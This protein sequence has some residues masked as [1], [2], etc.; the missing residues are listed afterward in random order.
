MPTA[1]GRSAAVGDLELAALLLR[2]GADVNATDV[3]GTAL[4]EAAGAGRLDMVKFLLNANALSAVCGATGYDGAIRR[5]EFRGNPAV[6]DLI[7]EH[8]A[9]VEAGTVFNPELL[10]AQQECRVCESDSD[11]EYSDDSSWSSTEEDAE[12]AE[13]VDRKHRPTSTGLDYME[14]VETM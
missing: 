9:K 3:F 7:R 5:A 11:D 12:H 2:E 1:L 6:A 4:D 8:A 10:K 14:A 13:V